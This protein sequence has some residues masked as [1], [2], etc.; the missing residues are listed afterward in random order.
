MGQGSLT[1]VF[2]S[3]P[4]TLISYTYIYMY[5]YIFIFIYIC[6]HIFLSTYICLYRIHYFKTE[7]KF[8]SFHSYNKFSLFKKYLSQQFPAFIH[9]S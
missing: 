4:P 6:S 5:V 8:K 9:Y 2:L 1:F 7:M 3:S